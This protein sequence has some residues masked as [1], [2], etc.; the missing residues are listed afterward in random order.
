MLL[1]E[2]Y[3]LISDHIDKFTIVKFDDQLKLLTQKS[4]TITEKLFEK[5]N[6]A[7]LYHRVQ[8][9]GDT[10]YVFQYNSKQKQSV[11]FLFTW[12]KN[13]SSKE[14]QFRFGSEPKVSVVNL[15]SLD[16]NET[17]YYSD[18]YID[19]SGIL[20]FLK[21]NKQGYK[22]VMTKQPDLKNSKK[23]DVITN[24]TNSAK[25]GFKFLESGHGTF[26]IKSPDE[27]LSIIQYNGQAPPYLQAIPKMDIFLPAKE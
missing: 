13:N 9:F 15:N 21:K 16:D 23:E 6:S 1:V 11:L 18:F 10:V 8:L 7:N 12:D 27:E 5:F 3:I 26:V 24:I 25:E 20:N 22:V 14:G 17:L 19:R 2:N 4:V